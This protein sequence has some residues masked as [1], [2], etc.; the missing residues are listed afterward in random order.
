MKHEQL[1]N[2][3]L[4]WRY[5]TSKAQ[6][7]FH[8]IQDNYN[9][10]IKEWVNTLENVKSC[11]DQLSFNTSNDPLLISNIPLIETLYNEL[12]A[13]LFVLGRHFRCRRK[14]APLFAPDSACQTD[15]T[16]KK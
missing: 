15:G 6:E 2:D 8:L 14:L 4:Q 13:E 1:K 5:L 16:N 10:S 7:S 12:E 9:S 11:V 3:I